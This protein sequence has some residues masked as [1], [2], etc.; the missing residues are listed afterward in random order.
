[1]TRAILFAIV[2]LSAVLQAQGAEP[3]AC[4]W[5]TSAGAVV[6]GEPF[7]V[8]LTCAV[9][10]DREMRVV[11]DESRLGV[12]AIQLTPFE[13]LG[14]AH[15]A[16]LRR[17]ERRFF[18]YRYTVRLIDPDVIGQ[19]ASLPDVRVQYRIESLDS[20]SSAV[21]GRDREYVLQGQSV[22]VLSLVPLGASDIR[23]AGDQDFARGEG[24]R[25]R[26]RALRI[27]AFV[28]GA[29]GLVLLL[30][31]IARAVRR[32]PAEAQAA[33]GHLP[34]RAVLRHAVAALE[35][36]KQSAQGGWDPDLAHRAASALRVAAACALGRPVSQRPQESP[37]SA[38]GRLIVPSGLLKRRRVSVS[39]PVT[40]L[41]LEKTGPEEL[42]EAIAA[43]TA[44]LYQPA[45]A[46]DGP[47]LDA[48][49]AKALDALRRAR[50]PR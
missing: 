8:V 31:A 36:I 44:A 4:W 17:G 2:A 46:P 1:M 18:Q 11:V 48:A 19:D 50:V 43:F 29:L 40:P 34:A 37:E 15:P 20:G 14:G 47:A 12:D 16:D 21:E 39:S 25:F 24:L 7:D 42:R 10:E 9:R 38:A 22:R 45:F 26:A 3:I 35:Q 27:G 30:P 41:D 28:L 5:R 13:V 49:L 6:T 33:A 32:R 23:D